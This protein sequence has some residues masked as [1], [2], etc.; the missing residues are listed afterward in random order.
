MKLTFF[1][2]TA[3][4]PSSPTKKTFS[5]S[6]IYFILLTMG[7]NQQHKN[8]FSFDTPCFFY[9]GA[10]SG[11]SQRWWIEEHVQGAQHGSRLLVGPTLTFPDLPL[12]RFNRST[13]C[14]DHSS[15]V[16]QHCLIFGAHRGDNA[17]TAEQRFWLW[18][19]RYN[20]TLLMLTQGL[21]GWLPGR[22]E[23]SASSDL[24][25]HKKPRPARGSH[26]GGWPC[27]WGQEELTGKSRR[28]DWI[29]GKDNCM[30]HVAFQ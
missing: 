29:C 6:L 15:L 27:G 7:R 10:I 5:S 25:L 12:W 17:Q 11:G 18:C 9:T 14:L 21:Y 2:L 4:S 20:W 3:F 23:R 24:C 13:R 26:G 19:P 1:A 8:S 28:P 30:R 16:C 22:L